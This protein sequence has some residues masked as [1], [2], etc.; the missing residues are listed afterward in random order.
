M[1]YYCMTAEFTPKQSPVLPRA[2][3]YHMHIRGNEA[4]KSKARE[5]LGW[6]R[7]VPRA[8]K[9][10]EALHQLGVSYVCCFLGRVPH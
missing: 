10:K 9:L 3:P 5:G 4:P 8:L 6:T 2:L 1:S 7:E